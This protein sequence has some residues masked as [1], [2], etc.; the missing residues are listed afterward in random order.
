VRGGLVVGAGI[1]IGNITGFFRVGV[2]AYLLGT[3][4]KADALAV[5]IGPVDSLNSAIVNTM[6]V[7]FVPMLLLRPESDRA[8]VFAR[9]ARVFAWILAAISAG[10][11]LLASPIISLL[12][13]G[14][15]PDQHREAVEL[16]RFTAP[17]TL[18]AGGSA[19]Y[20]ALLY[21]ERRFFIPALYQACLNGCTIASALL[22]WKFLGP[23]GFAVGYVAGAALQL[24]IA[25]AASRDLVR[26]AGE[27][28][29]NVDSEAAVAPLRE[30]LATPGMFLAYAGLLAVNIVVTR[31]F[32]THAGPGMAAAFDY[33]LR[34]VSVVVAYLV[35]PVANSLLPEIARMRGSLQIRRAYAL[36]D[37]SI[38]TM[39]VIAVLACVV[40][41]AIR[42][43]VIGLLFERGSFTAQSTLL[44]SGVFLGFAP[45]IIG[46]AL[47]D[48]MSR[49]LFALDRPKLPMFAGFIPLATNVIA[50]LAM[51]HIRNPAYLCLG[52]SV[53]FTVAF[54][55]LFITIHL[56]RPTDPPWLLENP[57]SDQPSRLA[58]IPE[59]RDEQDGEG[60]DHPVHFT[61]AA[62]QDFEQRIGAEAEREPVR[63]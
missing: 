6:L 5:A 27:L 16:L 20:G 43:E 30:I 26:K 54:V 28:R 32:A 24:C 44:V 1:L 58:Q 47:L 59:A 34:C 37:K 12:G 10:A 15:A 50:I 49:C 46:W 51:G 2:T 56:R 8:I 31:A 22:F 61:E 55:L 25:W 39:A 62:P 29:R 7:S 35:Y 21:T 17:S 3:H 42:T 48:L 18:L 13:P 38:G 53:G 4:A 57:P 52:N 36:L 63:D 19:I 33:C 40:G 23:V 11:A 45:G 14:L 9:A 60:V 41:I